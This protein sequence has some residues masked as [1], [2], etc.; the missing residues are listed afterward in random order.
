[1]CKSFV[2]LV[3]LFSTRP[4]RGVSA[5]C[6]LFLWSSSSPGRDSSAR[7]SPALRRVHSPRKLQCYGAYNPSHML[8]FALTPP[9]PRRHAGVALL[10]LVAQPA[11]AAGRP[12]RALLQ[13][14]YGNGYGNGGGGH[15]AGP[16]T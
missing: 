13:F 16:S 14:R 1:M 12:L 3:A 2:L 8:V 7:A 15:W 5:E 9:S 11:A 4:Q 10:A 6:L